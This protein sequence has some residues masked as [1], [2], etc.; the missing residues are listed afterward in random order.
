[1]FSTIEI[2]AL[3]RK[4]F[5]NIDN[6]MELLNNDIQIIYERF[7]IIDNDVKYKFLKTEFLIINR[8]LFN[9]KF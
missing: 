1:M 4:Y 8:K 2:D 5:D 7:N 6:L 9:R 3:H